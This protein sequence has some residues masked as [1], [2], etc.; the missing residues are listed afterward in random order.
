[1]KL[2]KIQ[3]LHFGYTLE[4]KI[5]FLFNGGGM[6]VVSHACQVP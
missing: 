4:I 5:K 6:R 3:L 2:T 1:M